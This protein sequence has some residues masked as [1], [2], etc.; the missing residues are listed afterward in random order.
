MKIT[1]FYGPFSSKPCLITGGYMKIWRKKVVLW[2]ADSTHPTSSP[3]HFPRPPVPQHLWHF[4]FGRLCQGC[5]WVNVGQSTANIQKLD[6]FFL[7]I[8][9]VV[10]CFWVLI[11]SQFGWSRIQ[12]V[13]VSALLDTFI[14]R[15]DRIDLTSETHSTLPPLLLASWTTI[16]MQKGRVQ[17]C[18]HNNLHVAAGGRWNMMKH[19]PN[20]LRAARRR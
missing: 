20:F 17:W 5:C 13:S 10:C 11:W 8:D 18:H 16:Y 19:G 6:Y 4:P 7:C 1:C 3:S 14:S 15:E 2:P 9:G 12:A